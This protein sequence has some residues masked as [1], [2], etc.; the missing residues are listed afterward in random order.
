VPKV[1][2]N[3]V[4]QKLDVRPQGRRIAFRW[5]HNLVG[6]YDTLIGDQTCD[7]FK[8]S[9]SDVG[10]F[11]SANCLP[12]LKYNLADIQ[13]TRELAVLAGRFVPKSDFGMKN[14]NPPVHHE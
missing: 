9:S 5:K 14:L 12:L 3:F 7:P 13:R 6:V 11:K 8:D 4:Q 10:A 2:T 1:V